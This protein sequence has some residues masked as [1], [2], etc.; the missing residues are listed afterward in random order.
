MSANVLKQP[1]Q[2]ERISLNAS[3]DALEIT[4]LLDAP[5]TKTTDFKSLSFIVG[6]NCC[7]KNRG[8]VKQSCMALLSTRNCNAGSSGNCGGR[9][10]IKI[11]PSIPSAVACSTS[12]RIVLGS[13]RSAG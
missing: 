7:N 1:T 2:A 5:E 13:P 12:S 8:P 10:G 11:I 3:H 4:C 9:G 6:N